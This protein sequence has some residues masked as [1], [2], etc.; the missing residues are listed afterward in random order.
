MLRKLIGSFRKDRN[1][2]INKLYLLVHPFCSLS[3]EEQIQQF[4]EIW[5]DSVSDASKDENAFAITYFAG[6]P[7]NRDEPNKFKFYFDKPSKHELDIGKHVQRSFGRNRSKFVLIQNIYPYV[8]WTFDKNVE[9]RIVDP[10]TLTITARGVYAERCVN[11]GRL[12]A[13]S[14]YKAPEANSSIV[15]KESI[16]G[17]KHIAEKHGFP[18]HIKMMI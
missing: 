18:T 11:D 14:A 10:K 5:M 2:P 4:R 17:E 15:Y 8:I 16:F 6:L 12:A 3:N 13:I 7:S 1:T 9:S